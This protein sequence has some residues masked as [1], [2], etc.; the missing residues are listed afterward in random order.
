VLRREQGEPLAW[1]T[2]TLQF[3]G[4]RLR[5][6][7]GVY[8][9]RFQ[10]EEL[11]RRAAELLV[12]G[13]WAA[14]LC[15]GSGA[16]GAHLSA[17]AANATV[18][19]VEIDPRA[20]TCAA[21]NGVRVIVG[22]LDA[23][24]RPDHRF[25]VVTAVAPYVPTDQLRLLPR[26]V[27]RYEPRAALDG[28]R[29]GLDLLRRVVAG[30]SRLLRRGGWLVVEVGGAQDELLRPALEAAGFAEVTAWHDD[31]GDLRGVAARAATTG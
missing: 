17:V 7:P 14:D 22:D 25:D 24:I 26:D 9:P 13:A 3:C 16:V 21:S 6:A 19:G 10:T 18:I 2:G 15:A 29:D 31:D 28:G 4:R 12:D 1:I 30:A 11:A 23:P 8:V 20:A 5:I 27:R